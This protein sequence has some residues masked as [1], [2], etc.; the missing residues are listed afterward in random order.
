MRRALTALA[1]AVALAVPWAITTPSYAAGSSTDPAATAQTYLVLLQGAPSATYD[2]GLEGLATTAPAPGKRYDADRPAVRAYTSHL[3]HQQAQ[4]LD[5]LDNPTKIY[6]YTTALNGFAAELTHAQVKRLQ[7]MPGVRSVQASSKAH[8]DAATGTVPPQ[9]GPVHRGVAQA[10]ASGRH[11]MA[12]RHRHTTVIGVI[13]SG[14]WPENPSFAGIPIGAAARE[15]QLPGFTG[16]CQPGDRWTA[17]TCDSKVVAGRYFA[18]AFGRDNI[19]RA[20]YVSP[21][22][23][24]GHGSRTAAIAAGH[25]GVDVRIEDQDFGHIS[26]TAPH[27]RL[28]IYKA[29]WSAPDPDDDGCTTA[30]TV[31]AIDQAVADGVDVI[32]YSI[33]GATS[34]YTTAV[35]VAFRGAAASGV[36]VATSA[37]NGGPSPASVRHPSPWVTTVGANTRDVY[38]GAVR[39]GNGSS[40]VGAMLS[41]TSVGPTRLVYAG[42]AAA[43]SSDRSHAA[44][45]YPG[46][47]DAGQVDDAIVVCDRGVVARVT[48]STAVDRAGGAGMV[49]VNRSRGSVDADQHQVPTVHLAA[50]PGRS[51]KTYID[52]AGTKASATLRAD[53]TDHPKVPQIAGFSGRGPSVAA[54]GDILK[55][56]VTAPGVSVVAASSPRDPAGHLWDVSSGTSM[57][58]PYVAGLA[59]RITSAHPRWTP[60]M[61]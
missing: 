16:T 51:V 40:F 61:I 20:D 4:V 53:G 8:L 55:P 5:A 44:L 25:S 3:H 37:G 34:S 11:G 32:N 29:C 13:G 7:S 54:E 46:S 2:G 28:A 10:D 18:K 22:D 19:A 60:S 30:D 21:R 56:D 49:L 47:L 42:D 17:E 1:A 41:E 58:A 57:A 9:V 52:H 6:S 12:D 35:D 50:G 59:A 36:F 15:R 31:K 48:K 23:A 38:Q 33:S 26:G 14:I 39:L 43:P 45:C 24:N 27:A